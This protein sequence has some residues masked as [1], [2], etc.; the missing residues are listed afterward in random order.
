[1]RTQVS[2]YLQQSTRLNQPI[3]CFAMVRSKYNW[4]SGP[5]SAKPRWHAK[6]SSGS[7]CDT[8]DGPR[9]CEPDMDSKTH[10][11]HQEVDAVEHIMV[12]YCVYARQVWTKCQQRALI[13]YRP[14]ENTDTLEDWWLRQRSRPE[15]KEQRTLDTW[16]VLI[17]WHIWKQKN[18]RVFGNTTR[19]CNE[20]Y[21]VWEIARS[22]ALWCCCAGLLST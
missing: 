3:R 7:P 12:Q 13:K 2:F 6:S 10:Q 17:C 21:L 18:V 15:K 19:Q 1:M 5:G 11:R 4:R 20:V 8:A 22:A 9:T 16:I 14:P